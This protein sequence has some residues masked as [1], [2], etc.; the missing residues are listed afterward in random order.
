VW[1]C[2]APK[3]AFVRGAPSSARAA[4]AAIATEM[5]STSASA[6]RNLVAP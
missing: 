3:Y 4:P 1:T 5:P 6:E 2:T